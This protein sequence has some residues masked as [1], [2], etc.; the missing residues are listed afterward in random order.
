MSDRTTHIAL[1]FLFGTVGYCVVKK[2]Q[3]E[4]IDMGNAIG[5]GIVGAG[6]AVL[7]DIIEP[8]TSPMH[9]AFAHSVMAA[10]TATCVTKM[11]WDSQELSGEQKAAI[12][13]LF[14]A[15]MSHLLADS[16]TPAGLPMA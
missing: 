4:E 2:L 9:R 10:G 8:A 1:G 12:V 3:N 7:P 13:S 6:V 11:A 16:A 5:W 14:G 15:Y